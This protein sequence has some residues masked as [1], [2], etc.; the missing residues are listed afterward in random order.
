MVLAK[1]GSWG[2]IAVQ[3]ED[4]VQFLQSQ[5]SNDVAG[6]PVEQARLSCLCT[7][8]GRML[9]SFFVVRGPQGVWL[10]CRSELLAPLVKRLSMFVLR[11]KVK[12]REA[13]ELSI[14]WQAQ[15][16]LSKPLEV[17]WNAESDACEL[18]LWPLNKAMPALSIAPTSEVQTNDQTSAHAFAELEAGLQ[19]WAIAYITVS[20]VEQFVPQAI[21]FD[22]VGGISFSKGCYPGQEIVA[23][24]HYLGKVKR[25]AF[26]AQ[27]AASG[28]TVELSPGQDV[29]MD[30][31]T[32]EPAGLVATVAQHGE[33]VLLMVELPVEDAANTDA[34]FTVQIGNEQVPIELL[35]MPYDVTQK[36]D[37]SASLVQAQ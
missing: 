27:L 25:R 24:S 32:N 11:S 35:S 34:R 19:H 33:T 30:G 14:G 29:W 37:Q 13:S 8:K 5:L 31:K 16:S 18:A 21:N 17:K 1:S 15:S 4:A 10:L 7:A 9:G 6:Q 23:R 2:V 28:A 12:I 26:R 3:G 22:L 20:T 36:G